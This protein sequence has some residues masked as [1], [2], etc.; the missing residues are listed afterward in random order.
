MREFQGKKNI[1]WDFDG[2]ILDSMDIRTMGFRKVLA[3]YPEVQVNRLIAFHKKNGGLSRYVKFRHFLQEIRKEQDCDRQVEILA[4]NYSEIMRKNLTS[5]RRLIKEVVDFIKE[6]HMSYKMHIVSG[7]DGEEL[8]HLCNKLDLT[9]YFVSIE[10]SPTPK[11]ELVS[12]ILRINNY[13]SKYTC[14]V[15]DSINDLKA[16]EEN[17]IDFFGYNNPDLRQEVDHY[18]GAFK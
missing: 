13:E 6:N 1:L 7:S 3:N 17:G 10:G 15:G 12:G 9:K 2:V 14:L 11:V 8:R 18:I 5:K 16:A 4:E